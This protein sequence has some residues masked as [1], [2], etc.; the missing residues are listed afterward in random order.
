MLRV[1][2]ED[3]TEL[4]VERQYLAAE[5]LGSEDGESGRDEGEEQDIDYGSDLEP[6]E[7]APEAEGEVEGSGSTRWEYLD[8]DWEP[9]EINMDQ[10]EIEKVRRDTVWTAHQAHRQRPR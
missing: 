7:V 6:E 5:E 9:T 3:G 1:R 10:R 8:Q 2:L 4:A